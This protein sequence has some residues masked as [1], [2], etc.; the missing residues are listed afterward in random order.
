MWSKNLAS[1]FLSKQT[2]GLADKQLNL[3][4]RLKE[5]ELDEIMSISNP[6]VKK[7]LLESY[8][9]GCDSDAV[10]LKAVCFTSST[11]SSYPTIR[12]LKNNEC[13]ST[14]YKEGEE[15]A[16]IRYPHGGTFEIPL[17][18]VTNKNKESKSGS[19][20]RRKRCYWNQL[21]GC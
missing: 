19:W 3:A 18:R 12:T 4:K 9:D 16:L 14:N 21:K 10:H 2:I 5:D 20:K 15:V 13:Y 6:T 11:V 1:Q 8:A 17:V 7:K